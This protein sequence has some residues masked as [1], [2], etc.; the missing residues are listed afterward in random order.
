M[1]R[2]GSGDVGDSFCKGGRCNSCKSAM[3]VVVVMVAVLVL[4]VV[5]LVVVVVGM[6][7]TTKVNS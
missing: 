2:R 6:K 4:L 5:V 7:I 1:W 3:V